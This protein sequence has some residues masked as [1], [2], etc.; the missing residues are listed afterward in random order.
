MK[1]AYAKFQINMINRFKIDGDI[2]ENHAFLAKLTAS[3]S[4][5]V[6][7]SHYLLHLNPFSAGI[8]IRGQNLM[9]VLVRF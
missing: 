2:A 5:Q 3:I 8:D 7:I 6:Y 4:I 9:S 1:M